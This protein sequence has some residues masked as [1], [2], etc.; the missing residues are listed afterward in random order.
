[1]LYDGFVLLTC[2]Y[3]KLLLTIFFFVNADNKNKIGEQYYK[4]CDSERN[5]IEKAKELLRNHGTVK[6]TLPTSN[7]NHDGTYGR[8]QK[9]KEK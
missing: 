4:K 2:N 8:V 3:L 6:I 7:C 5:V 9:I 1:M